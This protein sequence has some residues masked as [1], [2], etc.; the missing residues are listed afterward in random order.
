MIQRIITMISCIT[1]ISITEYVYHFDL[2]LF[3]IIMCLGIPLSFVAGGLNESKPYNFL[4]TT[5]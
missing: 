1:T 4:E 3:T 2:T 5:K